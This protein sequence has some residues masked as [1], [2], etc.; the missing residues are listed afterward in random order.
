MKM[1]DILTFGLMLSALFVQAQTAQDSIDSRNARKDPFYM[2][3]YGGINK[4][5][6]E[7]LPWT[8]FS[9]Y[10]WSGGGFLAIG[11]E[12]SPLW[13]W[14][15]ALRLNHNKSRNVPTCESEDAYGWNSLGLF[16]DVT[17]DITDA[18]HRKKI[19][20]GKKRPKFNVKA[21]AG[22]GASYTWSYDNVPL[23]YT[24]PY[25]R[26]SKIVPA[27]RVG[28]NATYRL[29]QRWRVGAELSQSLFTDRFNGVAY[30]AGVDGR[31]NLKVGLTYLFMKKKK[32]RKPVVRLNKLRECPPIMLVAPDPENQK[33]RQIGGH[34]FLD[35][36]VNETVIYPD[37]RKNPDEL[38]RI[39]NSID[40]AMFDRS[41]NITK[42]TL[43]GYASPESPYSNNTRLAKGRTE[44][45]KNYLI[46]KYN[47]KP[48]LFQT[49]Y[50]PE[51][52]GNLE[53]FLIDS[54][55]RKVKG[56]FWYDSKDYFETPEVPEIVQNHRNDL[57][58]VIGRN[59]DPDAKE[60]LLKKV[61]GGEPYK[62]LLEY[63]YPGLRHTDYIIDYEIMPF[64]L[65]KGRKLIY[66]HPEALSLE[67]MYKVAVSYK[68]RS[69]DWLDA[70]L[71]AVKQYPDDATANL[72]AASA[73]V[74]TGRLIDAKEYL[75]KA[76]DSRE[77]KY[78][79]N[80]IQAMEGSVEWKIEQDKVIIIEKE[81]QSLKNNNNE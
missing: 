22:V 23:S 81:E 31:T 52:W 72:N 21:F 17:F 51:D 42:I 79:A 8:E 65:E 58:H 2:Q 48:Q 29:S 41:V 61:G 46:R 53:G 73:C 5:A 45:L 33:L 64:S 9:S 54:K 49:E 19:L 56:D 15:A 40:S 24:H 70:L 77:A 63:V 34:A 16:G 26:S 37:Y 25:S 20:V 80:I 50:T 1:R 14:R 76:G 27:M 75:K 78:V 69:D 55:T 36:P 68:E 44:A 12:L 13:G 32:V 18:I 43:H 67:E 59:M 38:A 11:R 71:I 57:L 35:F 7:N 60:E 3:L 4:S 10:P 30:G 47:F 66:T 39:L 74:M 28:V 6:N 62:W